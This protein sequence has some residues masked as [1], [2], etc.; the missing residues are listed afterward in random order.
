MRKLAS[1]VKIEN[2]EKIKDSDFLVKITMYGKG[3]EVVC[4]IKD[5][6][7]KDDIAVYFEIDSALPI[8]DIRY[9]FLKDRCK[10]VWKIGEKTVFE[11]IKIKT[12]NLRGVVSQGLILP[13]ALFPELKNM[14]VDEDVTDILGVKHFDDVS[15]EWDK[16]TGKI[17]LDGEF[18]ANFPSFIN[19]TDEERIQNFSHFFTELKGTLWEVTDKYDGSSMTCFYSLVNRPSDPFG[20]C[21]RNTEYWDK[22]KNI[23]WDVAK[24]YEL[25][26]KMKFYNEEIAFQGE[27]VGPG[28][29]GNR[30]RYTE[31]DF[32]VFNIFDISNR[33]YFT[34]NERYELCK[35]YNLNHVR[36]INPAM[37]VFNELDSLEKML[38][39]VDGKTERGNRKEGCVFKSLDGRSSFKCIN[40]KYLLSEK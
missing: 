33:R 20:V 31:H 18:K 37:D 9:D 10:R 34:P 40:N 1:I 13:I 36:V 2:V 24:K 29:N 30:D 6:F 19:K 14:K 17:T 4:H 21:N 23:Y 15:L 25:F 39:F 5:N 38:K 22:D 12:I 3:W 32:F 7:K 35:K 26:E 27:L 28:I 16:I 8:D 11:T